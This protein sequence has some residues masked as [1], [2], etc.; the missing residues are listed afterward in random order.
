MKPCSKCSSETNGFY[1]DKSRPD[2][3]SARCKT[4][5]KAERKAG[6]SREKNTAQSRV[7]RSK[8]RLLSNL[9]KK[10]SRDRLRAECIDKYG[11]KCTCCDNAD[12]R[13]LAIDHINGGGCAHRRS[14]GGGTAFLNWLKRS[15]YPPGY[16]ILCHNCNS[17]LGLYGYCPHTESRPRS[18]TR[19]SRAKFKCVEH[20]GKHCPC[21]V[22][23][24]EHLTIDH[25][26]GGGTKERA[27]VG[28][29]CRFYYWLIRSGFPAG[30]Q[31]LCWN[32]NFK[33]HFE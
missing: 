16:R 5:I 15:G 24:I 2:G 32:C 10:N 1:V 17:S 21:G 23:A 33:K 3:L 30:Y 19:H 11:G 26:D 14:I 27:K 4:C 12:N 28:G 9:V 31:V 6:Y 20:Y 29:G 8:N 22:T 7:W 13:C 25:I 18:D